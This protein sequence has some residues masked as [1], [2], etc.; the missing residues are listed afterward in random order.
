LR[1]VKGFDELT[2][3]LRQT[4]AGV[5]ARLDAIDLVLENLQR[6]GPIGVVDGA[7]ERPQRGRRRRSDRSVKPRSSDSAAEERRQQLHQ[8][9]AKAPHGLT[10]ADLRKAF[11]KMDGKARS[12]ALHYLKHAGYVSR[13]GNS[14]VE[15]ADLK[16]RAGADA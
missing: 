6:L 7:L 4:R 3:I 1:T 12:N 16:Q 5:Q 14:W 13:R 10:V 8:A 11:P 2:A 9:I 15:N